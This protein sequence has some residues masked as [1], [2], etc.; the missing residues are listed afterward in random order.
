MKIEQAVFCQQTAAV[1]TGKGEGNAEQDRQAEDYKEVS[2]T[3]GTRM[4][5]G[6]DCSVRGRSN[7]FLLG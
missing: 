3:D 5:T 4:Q 1:Y 7:W 2:K 6:T